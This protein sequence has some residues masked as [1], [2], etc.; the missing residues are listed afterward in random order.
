MD[1]AL[2][3][4]SLQADY[5][6]AYTDVSQSLHDFE[7]V[8]LSA[9][10]LNA[11]KKSI[12]TKLLLASQGA[13]QLEIS[14]DDASGQSR[15]SVGRAK[16]GMLMQALLKDLLVAS[17]SNSSSHLA[18]QLEIDIT[19]PTTTIRIPQKTIKSL[20]KGSLGVTAFDISPD[21]AGRY[22]VGGADGQAHIGHLGTAG[23]EEIKTYLQGHVGDVRSASFFPSGQVVFT[24]ASDC[25]AR[26]FGLDGSN[27]RT[28]KGHRRG[29]TSSYILGRGREVLTS[30]TDGT[31]RLWDVGE[32]VQ[33][34]LFVSHNYSGVNVVSMGS[35]G[36]PGDEAD[37]TQ[38]GDEPQYQEKLLVTGLSTGIIEGHDALSGS[39]VFRLPKLHFPS[40]PAPQATDW[41]EQISSS[42]ITSLDW[43]KQN[44]LLLAGCS[45]GVTVLHDM[46]MLSTETRDDNSSVMATW[47]RNGA[48][49]NHVRLLPHTNE[50]VITTADGTPYRVSFH[51]AAPRVTEEYNGWDVDNVQSSALDAR[52]RVWLA[53]ADGIIRMY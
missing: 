28:L 6:Q 49:I 26:I 48:S 22:V 31:T 16:N 37:E 4:I 43:S 42:S 15:L 24:T 8:W 40:G 23:Q 13:D 41:W 27:P 36:P 32:G 21:L 39:S 7:K 51:D 17:T 35:K 44:N 53:G 9:Y 20:V 46:R 19:I 2:P 11:P 1:L 47:R 33:K 3:Y 50:S 10:C 5:L 25:T 30:S 14:I 12:H 29:V 18:K 45:N 52:G 38:L 34:R